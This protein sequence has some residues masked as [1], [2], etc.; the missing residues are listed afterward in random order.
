MK[1]TALMFCM[2]ALVCAGLA[3]AEE[4]PAPVDGSLEVAE[5]VETQQIAEAGA[6]K[7]AEQ[8]LANDAEENGFA[9]AIS[10]SHCSDPWTCTYQEPG[11]GFGCTCTYSCQC[12]TC[13]GELVHLNCV[14][15]DDGG[16]FA[17]PDYN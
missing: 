11:L 7:N 13:N 10:R 3:T 4:A 17:C 9:A 6:E 16:C 14:L 15:I 8:C 2:L 12:K 5:A 1:K